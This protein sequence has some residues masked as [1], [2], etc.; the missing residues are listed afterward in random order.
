MT[1]CGGGGGGRGVLLSRAAGDKHSF[2]ATLLSRP[3]PLSPSTA[4]SPVNINGG[5]GGG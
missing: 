1:L 3:T 5:H 2:L 4:P